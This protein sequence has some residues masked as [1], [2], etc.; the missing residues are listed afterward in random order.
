MPY[1]EDFAGLYVIKNNAT[2]NSYVGQ[3]ARMRKRI[4]DHFNL[5]RRQKHP[6]Q[7][8]QRAF[9]KYGEDSFSY[10]FEVICEDPSE[11]DMLEECYLTGEAI[12]DETPVYYNIATTAQAPMR[13]R[14]H[15]EET[16]RRISESK[17]G[18]RSHVTPEYRAKLSAAHQ[19]RW[20]SD[21][22]HVAKIRFIVDN[23]DMSY[24]QRGRVIGLDTSTVRRLALRYQPLKGEL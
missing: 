10:D 14:H 23:P 17:L 16:K 21:E 8:L 19:K 3:S 2:S 1:A 6:N 24:A 13:G 4:A 20:L 9:L 12:F 18:Q 11:R 7:H 15:T 5:L 22:S